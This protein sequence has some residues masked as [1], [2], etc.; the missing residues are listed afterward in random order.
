MGSN[1]PSPRLTRKTS[2]NTSLTPTMQAGIP[3]S[4]LMSPSRGSLSES[5]RGNSPRATRQPS[6]GQVALQELLNNPPL[7]HKTDNTFAGRDWRKIAVGEIIDDQ[8]VHWV[9][10]DTSV[11]DATN[12]SHQEQ[13]EESNLTAL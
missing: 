7:A 6:L 13:L 11:E 10:R 9:E 8:E 5:L 2:Q 3:S 4:P 1:P 12:V